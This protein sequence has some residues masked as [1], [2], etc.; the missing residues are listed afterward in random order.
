MIQSVFVDMDMVLAD[1][2]R[3]VEVKYGINLPDGFGYDISRA[4]GRNWDDLKWELDIDFWADL[5]PMPWARLLMKFLSL[6]FPEVYILT[7]AE[8][9]RGFIEGKL[10]WMKTWFPEYTD[11]VIITKH[12]HL[13][14]RPTALLIDDYPPNCKSWRAQSGRAV[15][16]QSRWKGP[17]DPDYNIF[18]AI[19]SEAGIS[20]PTG[21][22]ATGTSITDS[23]I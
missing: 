18:D 13:L 7:H 10:L 9:I 1:F 6:E 4:I 22:S 20:Y 5:R 17:V 21:L 2:I 11:K 12:K 8:P 15:E 3:G 14:S 23:D 19:V 16:V